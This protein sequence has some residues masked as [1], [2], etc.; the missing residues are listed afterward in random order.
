MCSQAA[1]IKRT[2]RAAGRAVAAEPKRPKDAWDVLLS[3]AA[4]MANAFRR[5][6]AGVQGSEVGC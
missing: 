4:W 3:E 5:C 1:H 2:H 6:V